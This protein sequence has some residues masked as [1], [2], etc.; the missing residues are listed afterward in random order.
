M[1]ILLYE[2]CSGGGLW[3][4][5]PGARLAHE[6]LRE[7][8]AMRDALAADLRQCCGVRLTELQDTRLSPTDAARASDRVVPIGSARQE[9]AQLAALARHVDGVLL[10]AP[11]CD[12]RLL[13]RARWVTE[14]GG[15]LLS[16]DPTFIALASDKSRTAA[17]LAR[18]GVPV[19]TSRLLGPGEPLPTEIPPPLIL[20]P[21]DG[22]GSRQTYLVRQRAE[23]ERLRATFPHALRV[24]AWCPGLPA[25]VLALCG[26]R[27]RI[28]L[29][30]CSQRM[31]CQGTLHYQGGQFPLADRLRRRA[32]RLAR[33]A[34]DAL[35]QTS[36][37]V[38]VDLLLG[39]D[40]DGGRDVVLEV[41]PRLTTSY[42]A[43]RRASRTNLAAAM[44]AVL[45][46]Q[47]VALFFRPDTI[48]FDAD[49]QVRTVHTPAS[50]VP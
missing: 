27:R 44:L 49:G 22:A 32:C 15:R 12:G 1:H 45:R 46:G 23:G 21:N 13:E 38:G 16:A 34:L 33:A 36:G 5:A 37:F 19:P 8:R 25:S 48:E 7:G 28:E 10:V 20:K 4:D 11:E 26:P 24:E 42:V 35:P 14:Q 29:P 41:N 47:R 3:T 39:D 18:A 2:Y 30:P 40:P 17:E 43:L 50:A 6:L 31:R 9:R